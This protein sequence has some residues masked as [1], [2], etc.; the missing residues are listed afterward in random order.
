M[1]K[2]LYVQILLIVI[3]IIAFLP[4]ITLASKLMN[5]GTGE[6][7]LGIITLILAPAII[8]QIVYHEVRKLI[9]HF[10]GEPQ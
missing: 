1:K 2:H 8:V 10:K 7:Y 3:P 5:G 4:V 9:R 6:F